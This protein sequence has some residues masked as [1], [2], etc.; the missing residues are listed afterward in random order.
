RLLQDLAIR[1]LGA[2]DLEGRRFL[3]GNAAQF[4]GDER[5]VVFLTMVDRSEGSPLSM[6]RDDM[7]KQRYN[8]AASR[9]RDQLW[10]VHSLDPARHL[11]EEDLRRQLIN[12]VR[13]PGA[14]ARML[15]Q[16]E[17]RAE[18]PFEQ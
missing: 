1:H 2:I 10:L 11:R 6:R 16:A 5:D 7:F 3:A 13:D 18:S 15:A 9:A 14:R 17:A 4:Q 8:V 12:Y